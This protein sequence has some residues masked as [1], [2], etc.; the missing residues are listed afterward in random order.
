MKRFGQAG[1]EVF[2]LPR[3]K[4]DLT[5]KEALH[6]ILSEMKPDLLVHAAGLLGGV[7]FSRLY[8]AQVF[9]KNLAMACNVL[10]MAHEHKIEKLVNIGS[11]CIYSDQ[12]EGPFKESD[13]FAGPMHPS[14]RYYGFSKQALY[15]GSLAL[16]EQYH[17]HS[18]HLVLTNLYGPGDK[19]NPNL[20]HV[21]SSMIPKFYE[22]ACQN[23]PEVLCWGTGKTIREFIYV[24]DCAEAVLRATERYD[25]SEPLNVGTGEGITIKALAEMIKKTTGYKGSIKWDTTKPDGAA[26]KVLDVSRMRKILQWEPK[27][28]LKEGLKKTV[29][30]FGNHYEEWKQGQRR[31]L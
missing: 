29:E 12:L 3:E 20:S 2:S 26:Y 18:I 1:A 4:C 24:E 31:D 27:T 19:F 9:L 28:S 22:A 14:V 15:L 23:H 30:W 17:F 8:P 21:V 16:K 13:F 25:D 6:R 11:G 10:E 7:H 5:Q